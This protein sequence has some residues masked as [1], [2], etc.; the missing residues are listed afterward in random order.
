MAFSVNGV[1]GKR[2]PYATLDQLN[3]SSAVAEMGDRGHNRHASTRGAG[4]AVLLSR[5]GELGPRLTQYDLGRSL[6][7]DLPRKG[8]I[9]R[10]KRANRCEV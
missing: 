2:D 1:L 5:A 8:A 10:R 3:K 9:L 4:A 7:P 6:L